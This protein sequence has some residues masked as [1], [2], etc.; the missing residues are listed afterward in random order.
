MLPCT[1]WYIYLPRT[2]HC[3][4]IEISG[5]R[6]FTV[7]STIHACAYMQR[8]AKTKERFEVTSYYVCIVFVF[9]IYYMQVYCVH[10]YTRKKINNAAWLPMPYILH[11]NISS[12]DELWRSLR[13]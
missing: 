12:W 4:L 5:N 2:L 11:Q 10:V 13:E 9:D 7:Q 1:A 3:P 6:I 8:H